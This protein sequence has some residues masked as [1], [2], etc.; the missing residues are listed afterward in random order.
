MVTPP[1]GPPKAWYTRWWVIGIAVVVG[2]MVVSIVANQ[3]DGD[4]NPSVGSTG[5]GSQTQAAST[6]LPASPTESTLPSKPEDVLTREEV[7]DGWP[8]S[9]DKVRFI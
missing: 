1:P 2:M 3:P 8:L 7:G 4:D 9:V 5:S 6:A